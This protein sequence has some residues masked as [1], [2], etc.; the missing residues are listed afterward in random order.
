MRCYRRFLFK[1]KKLRKFIMVLKVIMSLFV[2]G[3]D[4][5]PEFNNRVMREVLFA[6]A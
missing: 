3:G 1:L 6:L 2:G 4:D 5:P